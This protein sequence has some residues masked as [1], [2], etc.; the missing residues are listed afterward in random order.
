MAKRS[1]MAKSLFWD[2]D[3]DEDTV[4]DRISN[5]PSSL[6]CHILSFLT[7]KEVVATSILSTRWKFL[8]ILVPTLHLEDEPLKKPVSFI[9]IVYRVLALHIAPLLR[10][11]SLTWYSSVHS[12]H[13]NT[14]IHTALSRNLQQLH[15]EIYLNGHGSNVYKG[16]RFKLPRSVY[17]CKTV[18]VLKLTGGIVLDPPSSFKFPERM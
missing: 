12:F 16:T 10:N 1:K 3:D 8:W 6:I 13:L 5:L 15:L 7:T 4:V 18:V 17:Y 9:T 14:W 2:D 11:F